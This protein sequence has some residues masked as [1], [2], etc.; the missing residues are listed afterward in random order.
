[1]VLPSGGVIDIERGHVSAHPDGYF[2]FNGPDRLVRVPIPRVV[3]PRVP[4]CSAGYFGGPGMDL[5]DLFIGSEG[6][7]GIVTEVTFVTAAAPAATFAAMIA[8][9]D[10]RTAWRLV[11]RLRGAAVRT[12]QTRDAAGI[13]VS[14]IEHLDRRSIELV[15]EDGVDRREH[16]TIRPDAEVVLFVEF[17]SAQPLAPDDAWRQVEDALT[18]TA[19][20]GPVA[21]VCRLLDEEGL[22]DAT[23]LALPGDG[24][25]R[26]QFRAVRE[27]VPDAVNRRVALAHAADPRVS[28]TAADVIVPV[29]RFDALMASCRAAFE[30]RGLDYAVWG[31]VSDGNVHPNAIPRAFDDVTKGREAVLDVGQAAIALGGSPLAEHGVGRNPV[32]QQLM[33]LLHGDDGVAS[34]WAVKRSLDPAGRLAPG[35]LL[36]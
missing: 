6:T 25:R 2:E 20:D 19:A 29:D 34:M 22:L 9:R 8:L 16:L 18:E 10:E 7:L 28:K 23:E 3:L 33:R 32:K 35:V 31:H 27:A 5:I 15:R 36:G 26:A 21:R 4:K 13:D 30:S 14:A 1:V 11:D 12:W 24:V 17:E